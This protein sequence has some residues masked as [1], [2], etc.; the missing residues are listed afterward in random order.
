MSCCVLTGLAKDLPYY[1]SRGLNSGVLLLSLDRLR[2]SGLSTERERLI[3]HHHPKGQLPLGDEDVLNA[4]AHAYP[5]L[6]H[7]LPCVMNF[8][9]D[10]G[11]YEGF[12]VIFHGKRGIKD[13]AKHPYSYLYNLFGA[14]QSLLA[15]IQ[16]QPTP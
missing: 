12:P 11:C 5:H 14:A 15:S 3:Q 13:D 9:S 1:G 10:P 6:V 7:V 4:Y 8:R 2:R 16:G